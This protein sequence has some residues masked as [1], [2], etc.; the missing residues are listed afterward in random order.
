CKVAVEPLP[1][2]VAATAVP[3]PSR[4]T[5]FPVVTLDGAIGSLNVAL[6][7]VPGPT[8]VAPA[9]G[10]V[11]ATVGGVV[12]GATVVNDQEKSA[13]SALPARS[14]TPPPTSVAVYVVE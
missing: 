4:R 2:A 5:K 10:T 1:D 3:F 8:P 13:A 14:F 11:L 7:L 9:A 6:M 12:S